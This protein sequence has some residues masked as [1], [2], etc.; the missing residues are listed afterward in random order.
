MNNTVT[1]KIKHFPQLFTLGPQIAQNQDDIT[2]FFDQL[3]PPN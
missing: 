2:F 1:N 3:L